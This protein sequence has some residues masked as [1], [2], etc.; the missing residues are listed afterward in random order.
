M[1]TILNNLQEI[2]NAH[3]NLITGE[4]VIMEEFAYASLGYLKDD[5]LKEMSWGGFWIFVDAWSPCE[6]CNVDYNSESSFL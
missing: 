5:A 3:D 6:F 4:G 1:E 2:L